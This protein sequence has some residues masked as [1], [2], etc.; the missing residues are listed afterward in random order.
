MRLFGRLVILIAGGVL[1]LLSGLLL[2]RRDDTAPVFGLIF[3]SERDGQPALYRMRLD[4][5]MVRHLADIPNASYASVYAPDG[6]Q[7]ADVIR[8]GDNIGSDIAVRV[9]LR[10]RAR[11]ITFHPAVDLSPTW[12]PDGEWIAFVSERDDRPE[13][14]II[15]HDGSGL[16]RLT[17]TQNPAGSYAPRW[18]A[19]GQ[20]IIYTSVDA[21][22]TMISIV[23]I[24]DGETRPLLVSDFSYGTL[25]V[26]PAQDWVVFDMV[27]EQGNRD[28]YRT[29]A[30]DGRRERLTTH[31]ADDYGAAWS[32]DGLWIVFTSMRDGNAELYRMRP[33]GGE[34]VRLTVAA[35]RDER[36]RWMTERVAWVFDSWQLIVGGLLL[37]AFFF[38]FKFAKS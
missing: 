7:M 15:Q 38:I 23:S 11:Q 14:Y 2:V 12:S 6:S 9:N 8:P 16:K 30:A 36:A 27:N 25:D 20:S 32:P 33:G 35:G 24:N 26:S 13:I 1:L 3:V 31:P 18:S 5:E 4:G 19:D 29:R 10:Q 37:S 34:V 17:T 28:I 22:Q 21:G